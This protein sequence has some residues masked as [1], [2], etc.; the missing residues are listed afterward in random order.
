[1]GA[2]LY[3]ESSK[4]YQLFMLMHFQIIKWS[5][6]T[7]LVTWFEA[8][9]GGL[10]LLMI[11][12]VEGFWGDPG[13]WEREVEGTFWGPSQGVEG[14]LSDR[15]PQCGGCRGDW[16]PWWCCTLHEGHNFLRMLLMLMSAISIKFICQNFMLMKNTTNIRTEKRKPVKLNEILLC[17]VYWNYKLKFDIKHVINF[18]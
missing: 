16:C 10:S 8:L 9:W 18:L 3:Q 13:G 7:H 12:E 5:P 11:S 17:H 14:Y 2:Q 4:P 6:S 15:W 1:M